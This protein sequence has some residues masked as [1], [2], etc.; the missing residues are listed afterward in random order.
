ME[1]QGWRFVLAGFLILLGVAALLNN[2]NLLPW[3]INTMQWFWLVVF[4]GA[5]VSFLAVYVSGRENN[6]W[7]LIPGLTLVGL[8]VLISN[9]L[10]DGSIGAGLFLGLIGLSFWLIYAQKR[11]FWWAI[12][13]GGVLASLALMLFLTETVSGTGE[14]AILFLG[15]G[16][17]FLLVYLLPNPEGRM[18]WALWPA[19]ILGFM[20]L[21]FTIGSGGLA[22][23]IFPAVL[24]LGGGW[25][26][27][28]SM[29]RKNESL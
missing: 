15:M 17:T 25:I 24:I 26:V 8:A 27:L 13:P 19:S 7:A 20:G 12:I 21:M 10:P 6:W 9:I 29:T 23:Y 16:L 11:E 18:R 22:A 28:R 5:G 14:P 3:D 4:G 1:R 2:L